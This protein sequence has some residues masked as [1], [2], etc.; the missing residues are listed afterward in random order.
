[1]LSSPPSARW[2]RSIG[3]DFLRLRAQALSL[4]CG[5]DLLPLRAIPSA[6]SLP[7]A[8]PW[9]PLSDPPSMQTAMDQ[10]ARTPRTP[11][12]SPAHV[13]HLSFEH[14]PHL[15]SLPYLISHKLTLS[16]ALP[17]L[18]TLVGEPR[19]S[20]QPSSPPKATSSHLELRPKVRN[21]F[22]C[23]VYLIYAWS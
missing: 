18:L 12:T 9:G 8:A 5:P 19:P 10:H 1:V 21:L 7:L 6:H 3:V 17:S 2:G 4:S 13:P 11:A 14:R 16:H 15:F 23:L 20:Y 22:I